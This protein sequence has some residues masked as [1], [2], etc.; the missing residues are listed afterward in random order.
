MHDDREYL[1]IDDVDVEGKRVLVRVDINSPVDPQTGRVTSDTRIRVHARTLE[2]LA[3]R[4][5]KVVVLAHQGRKGDPD[6]VSLRDHG[7]LLGELLGRP[8]K[9][10]NDIVGEKAIKAIEELN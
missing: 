4:E 1:T 3:A 10:V 2:E 7:R 5:A 9:F 8:V 6:F